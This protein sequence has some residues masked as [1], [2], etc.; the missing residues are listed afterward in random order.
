MQSERARSIDTFK[1]I[2]RRDT[3]FKSML[4]E[5]LPHPRLEKV[6][7]CIKGTRETNCMLC[8]SKGKTCLAMSTHPGV[9]NRNERESL[10]HESNRHRVT[11]QL[12]VYLF[13]FS[14]MIISPLWTME[15]SACNRI[16][17]KATNR[18]TRAVSKTTMIITICLA[19]RASV[20]FDQV[21]PLSSAD[22]PTFNK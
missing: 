16:G 10:H 9:S 4:I 14:T 17:C 21:R 15:F 7:N 1:S 13:T 12:S 22:I 6:S 2:D 18:N 3:S 19:F 20:N 8:K 11:L 5:V